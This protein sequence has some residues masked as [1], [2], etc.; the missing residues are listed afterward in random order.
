MKAEAA[1]KTGVSLDAVEA[2]SE[3]DVEV[4]TILFGAV[5]ALRRLSDE[6][7]AAGEV[8]DLVVQQTIDHLR[9]I[10]PIFVHERI[11]RSAA[12]LLGPPT[13]TDQNG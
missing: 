7:L 4:S 5:N 12:E 1:R 11:H 10:N 6:A 2:M 8:P 13:A 3:T 9:L